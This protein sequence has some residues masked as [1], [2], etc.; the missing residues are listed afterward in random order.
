M[1]EGSLLG[2][3]EEREEEDI[4]NTGKVEDDDGTMA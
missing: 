3:E 2:E 4:V 1:L